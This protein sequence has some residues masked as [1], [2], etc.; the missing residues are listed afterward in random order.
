MTFLMFPKSLLSKDLLLASLKMKMDLLSGPMPKVVVKNKNE[1]EIQCG[2][3]GC[4]VLELAAKLDSVCPEGRWEDQSS[5][6]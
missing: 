6:Q 1:K 2:D 3:C 4:G 5:N